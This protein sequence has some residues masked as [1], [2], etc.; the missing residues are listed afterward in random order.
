M[1]IMTKISLNIIC[2]IMFLYFLTLAK[3]TFFV[4]ISRRGLEVLCY[5]GLRRFLATIFLLHLISCIWCF[6]S[7][8][9]EGS[10]VE[11]AETDD[12]TRIVST[13]A[14]AK[15][16][17]AIIKTAVFSRQYISEIAN[18]PHQKRIYFKKFNQLFQLLKN[19]ID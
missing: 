19:A 11:Y 12:P 3:W 18:Q 15:G 10:D 9:R 2:Y 14:P 6:N 8:P 17:T 4:Y 7:R 16:A 13:R 1:A 5:R